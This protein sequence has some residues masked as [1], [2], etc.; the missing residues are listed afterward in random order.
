M[1]IFDG[2]ELKPKEKA[3]LGLSL[4]YRLNLAE[5]AELW[6]DDEWMQQIYKQAMLNAVERGALSFE[7]DQEE[8]TFN[9]DVSC[10]HW[11]SVYWEKT[12][13]AQDFLSWLDS[14]GQQKPTGC[15]LAL[16][17]SDGQML[18]TNKTTL[19][20]ESDKGKRNKQIEAICEVI[21][22]LGYNPLKIPEGGKAKIKAKCLQLEGGLFTDA[23]FDHAWRAA[24][25][26]EKISMQDKEKYLSKQD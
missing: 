26:L 8:R 20:D 5:I 13:T 9:A 25:K 19:C 23:G 1:G 2:I 4:P 22:S 12:T 6:T 14:E 21:K 18:N 16:W 24:N 7:V 17:W 15:L 3:E 11:N 10:W